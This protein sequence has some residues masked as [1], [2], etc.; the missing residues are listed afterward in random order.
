MRLY[1]SVPDFDARYLIAKDGFGIW[2]VAIVLNKQFCCKSQL[3]AILSRLASSGIY[4]KLFRDVSVKVSL[5]K[6]KEEKKK[7]E[8]FATLKLRDISGALV[9]LKWG[10]A[11]SFLVFL[12][13]IVYFY[14]NGKIAKLLVKV[15]VVRLH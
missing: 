3:N 1:Y 12:G 8:G 5:I 13:E 2:P 14:L 11:L 4:Q 9:L 15:N 7:D 6:S 10:Y